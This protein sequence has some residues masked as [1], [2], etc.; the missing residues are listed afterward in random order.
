MVILLRRISYNTKLIYL[1]SGLTTLAI[2]LT[3]LISLNINNL[4]INM[5]EVSRNYTPFKVI[6]PMFYI[7]LGI[8]I[9][10]FLLKL[11]SNNSITIVLMMYLLILLSVFLSSVVFFK[12]GNFIFSF[13]LLLFAIIIDIILSRIYLNSTF[14]YYHVAIITYLIL[15]NFYLYINVIF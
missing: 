1:I 8:D 6:Y 12:L 13:W 7:I 2:V 5:H 15:V 14:C 11:S 3:I 9:S 4:K 10:I